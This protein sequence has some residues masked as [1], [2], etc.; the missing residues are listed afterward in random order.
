L[1]AQCQLI[2][3]NGARL[4]TP[5]CSVQVV[6]DPYDQYENIRSSC[7]FTFE[8]N[9]LRNCEGIG[10]GISDM[11]ESGDYLFILQPSAIRPHDVPP[12][13]LR[14]TPCSDVAFMVSGVRGEENAQ[15][16]FV[17]H[18]AVLLC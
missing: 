4:E 6:L 17:Q 1:Q 13:R 14:T 12:E 11:T 2:D 8:N 9:C 7:A 15:K 3:E 18:C 5:I 16:R 10:L